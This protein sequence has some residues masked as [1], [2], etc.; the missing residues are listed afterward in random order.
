MNIRR[1]TGNA[2]IVQGLNTILLVVV[3]LVLYPASGFNFS[4]FAS[5]GKFDEFIMNHPG[6]AQTGWLTDLIYGVT[7]V[8]L[9]VGFYRRFRKSQPER[10][11]MQAIWSIIGGALFLAAGGIGT[12]MMTF[13]ADPYHADAAKGMAG[14]LATSVIQVSIET[15]A[16]FSVNIAIWNVC[17]AAQLS[18]AFH[19]A[20]YYFGYLTAILGILNLP[21]SIIAPNVAM[22]TMAPSL[23]GLLV[24]SFGVGFNFLRNPQQNAEMEASF[25]S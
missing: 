8:F 17:R 24:F 10:A 21:L 9:A 2:A 11:V 5:A 15:V 1:A 12:I 3:Y 22:M 16:I 7:V 23:L 19:P 6:L 20:V 4:D 25:A 14:I 13:L 18:K